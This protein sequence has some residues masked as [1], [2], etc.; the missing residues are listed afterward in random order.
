MEKDPCLKEVLSSLVP[1]SP[2]LEKPIRHFY[3]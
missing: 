1:L 2:L 3:E